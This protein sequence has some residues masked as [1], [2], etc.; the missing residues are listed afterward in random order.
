MEEKFWETWAWYVEKDIKEIVKKQEARSAKGKLEGVGSTVCARASHEVTAL[1]G[2][3]VDREFVSSHGF[4]V[5]GELSRVIPCRVT[6]IPDNRYLSGI[7]LADEQYSSPGR[8]DAI[9]G[10]DIYA[11]I[12][13]EGIRR[14]P[15]G[16]PVAQLTVFGWILTGP[17]DINSE[18][19]S[20]VHAHPIRV[21]ESL[22]T[23]IVKF[24]EIEEVPDTKVLSRDD[25]YCNEFFQRTTKRD[26]SGRFIVRLPF[27]SNALLR[28]SK[29]IAL[30][31]LLRSEKRR[32]GS[33]ELQKAYDS[34]MREY[35]ELDHMRSASQSE[36]SAALC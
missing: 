27:R 6:E 9:L 25:E 29:E 13:R 16:A 19:H 20:T 32:Q 17:V 5:L 11:D 4:L 15:I 18:S 24:W 3:S 30:A 10:A 1:I 31:C 28:D 8:V 12:L 7:Q 33:F 2:S 34:F 21:D 22:D 36:R 14:G 23:L 35:Q 26:Q